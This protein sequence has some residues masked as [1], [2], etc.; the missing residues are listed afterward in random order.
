LWIEGCHVASA[1][2][3]HYRILRSLDRSHYI[4]F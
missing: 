2:D 1:T 4:F 3:L